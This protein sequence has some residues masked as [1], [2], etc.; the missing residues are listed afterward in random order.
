MRAY[1]DGPPRHGRFGRRGA[2]A[3]ESL[4]DLSC[5][6]K[7]YIMY[8]KKFKEG[9]FLDPAAHSAFRYPIFPDGPEFV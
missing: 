6:L 5:D 2:A 9:E 8:R 3:E 7:N 4:K 1:L